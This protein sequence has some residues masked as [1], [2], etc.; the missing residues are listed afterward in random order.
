MIE[1]LFE[2]F[3]QQEDGPGHIDGITL[4]VTYILFKYSRERGKEEKYLFHSLHEN[5]T[6]VYHVF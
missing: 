4:I 1:K 6:F 2:I 3:S 5:E